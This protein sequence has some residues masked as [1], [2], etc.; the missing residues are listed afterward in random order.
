MSEADRHARRIQIIEAV[1]RTTVS[2]G[3]Q[4]ATFRSIAKEAGLSVRLVQ[5]YFGTK[6]Q[7][8]ADTLQQVGNEAVARI[9]E[10]LQGLGSD[11][12]PKARIDTILAQFLP[13]DSERREAMLVF[14]A[15]RTAALTD[16]SLGTS[17][18]AGL[19]TSLIE[20]IQHEL[21][22]AVAEGE[23]RPGTVPHS[24][25][26]VLVATMTGIAN[27]LLAGTFSAEEARNLL[28]YAID[29]SIP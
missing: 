25:A 8:L 15:L 1:V 14:I 13:L 20:T 22:R 12:R 23:A 2:G 6:D 7:L 4:A 18:E 9:G 16:P 21:E 5:Y 17:Q 24:E 29:L 28:D 3:L 19:D 11:P 27:G 26:V 10:A